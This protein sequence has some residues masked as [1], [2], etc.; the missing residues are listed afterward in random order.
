V[1]LPAISTI[2][3]GKLY[4]IKDI[5]GNA[6]RS[7]I[8]LST[9]G[10]DTFDN[11]FRPSTLYA[12]MST[13]FQSVLL[14]SDGALNWMVLQNYNANVVNRAA[15]FSPTSITGGFLWLDASVISGSDGTSITTWTSA[16]PSY[17]YN[18]TGTATLKTGILNGLK[19]MQFNTSQNMSLSAGITSTT[20]TFFFVSRQTGGTNRRVFIGNG[21]KL[22][23]YWGG[24]KS[25]LYMEG[26]ISAVASPA[27][28]TAWDIYTIT[29]NSS[30]GGNFWRYGYSLYT[31]GSSGGGLDGF[32][33]NTGGCCGGETSDCQIAEVILYNTTLT[34]TQCRQVEGYLAWKWGLQANLTPG[35][36]FAT[37]PP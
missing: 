27:S 26:W 22:Y 25:Q 5:C 3:P 4:Y 30:G 36:T 31:F 19:V 15:A 6:G 12:L 29:R 32:Y 13:N 24:G 16:T 8:I 34:D 37:N 17:S 10:L 33:I 23:G 20:F 1:Y 28:D 18:M 35:H 7:S 21:N 14:A 11:S 9:T 2:G